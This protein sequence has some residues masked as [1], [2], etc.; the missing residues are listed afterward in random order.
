MKG[1]TAEKRSNSFSVEQLLE[2]N[3]IRFD[4]TQST[5]VSLKENS[6]QRQLLIW[7]QNCL[8]KH[9]SKRRFLSYIFEAVR[10]CLRRSCFGS[11]SRPGKAR[12]VAKALSAT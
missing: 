3:P 11:N 7:R 1:K 6:S 10:L 4:F 12:D 2:G 9:E 5:L 8:S